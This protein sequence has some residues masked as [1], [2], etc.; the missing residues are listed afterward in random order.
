VLVGDEQNEIGRGCVR[1]A[2]L[3]LDGRI[4]NEKGR[5][6]GIA[7]ESGHRVVIRKVFNEAFAFERYLFY[8]RR[9]A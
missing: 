7:C 3:K 8:M 6:Q 1:H 9:T 2:E 5:A 4:A